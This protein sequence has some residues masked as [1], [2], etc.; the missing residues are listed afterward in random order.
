MSLT[1]VLLDR[2]AARRGA[3]PAG[4]SK[5]RLLAVVATAL[6]LAVCAAVVL[7]FSVPRLLGWEAQVVLSGSM[8]PALKTGGIAFVA[9]IDDLASIRPGDVITFHRPNGA[10]SLVTHRVTSVEQ[11]TRGLPQFKTKG[12]ANGQEDGWTVPAAN[13]VGVVKWDVP[14]LGHLVEFSR[15]RTGFWFFIGVPGALIVT[16][17]LWG[18]RRQWLERRAVQA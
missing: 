12:D 7:T 14:W 4:D 6:A 18:L 11:G 10:A 9:P 15:S 8:E 3:E 13:V 2:F 16:T 5:P 17:Q 1:R